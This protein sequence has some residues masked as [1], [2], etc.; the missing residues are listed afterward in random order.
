MKF[1]KYFDS[2]Q[3]DQEVS[4]II[5]DL[6]SIFSSIDLEFNLFDKSPIAASG[7]IYKNEGYTIS[8][9]LKNSKIDTWKLSSK[10][11]ECIIESINK[12]ELKFSFCL[13]YIKNT[14]PITCNRVT[15]IGH[16]IIKFNSQVLDEVAIFFDH[17]D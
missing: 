4:N 3:H 10:I 2:I 5:F 6:E 13:I 1:I 7:G 9:K 15:D 16:T 14:S 8:I 12:L 17:V 11:E